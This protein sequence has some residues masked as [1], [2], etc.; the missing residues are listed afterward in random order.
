MDNKITEQNDTGLK[1]KLDQTRS[2]TAP[3]TDFGTVM[4]TGLERGADAVMSA[5]QLAAPFVPGGAVLSAA[6]TGVGSLKDSAA[7]A[8]AGAGGTTVVAGNGTGLGYGGTGVG[9]T[10]GAAP[11]GTYSGSTAYA[12]AGGGS[13]LTNVERL[14]AGGDS[15]AQLMVASRQMQE[16]NMSFNMQY[17]MLQQKMQQDNRQ[18]TLLSNI[19]KTKHETAKNSINNVR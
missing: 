12:A 8:S 15:Q 2:R 7:A 10:V 16:M 13:A 3:Q 17:L 9:G 11:I 4:K 6:I 5:G 1:V 19:M 14:A 18:F